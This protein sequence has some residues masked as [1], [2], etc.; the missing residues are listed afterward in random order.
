MY[1]CKAT[2]LVLIGSLL[3]HFIFMRDLSL[4]SYYSKTSEFAAKLDLPLNQM[5]K[6]FHSS[7]SGNGGLVAL[8]SFSLR[9]WE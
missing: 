5:P 2:N 7:T 6:Y 1:I 9:F 4:L 3:A 8:T